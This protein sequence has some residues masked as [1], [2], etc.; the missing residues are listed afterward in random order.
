MKTEILA[1]AMNQMVDGGYDSLNFRNIAEQLNIS[2]ANIHHHFVNKE[3][4]A[5]E[6]VHTYTTEMLKNMQHLANA[7]ETDLPGFLDA[8]ETFFWSKCH[9]SGHCS[10]CVCEQVTR[11][12]DAPEAMKKM[13]EDF[14][15]QFN[16]LI[17][18]VVSGTAAAG[19]L[20]PELIPDEVTTQTN[21]MMSGMGNMARMYPSVAEAEAALHGTLQSW[22]KTLMA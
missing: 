12:S 1:L 18:Q 4:L 2:K 20:K 11:V 3:T 5:L 9:E 21:M 13:S 15:K 22:V 17:N 6:V 19:K 8:A 16:Q 10:I 7:F 14:S